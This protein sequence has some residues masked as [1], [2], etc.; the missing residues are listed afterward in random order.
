MTPCCSRRSQNSQFWFGV[1]ATRRELELLIGFLKSISTTSTVSLG[2]GSCPPHSDRIHGRIDQ[3]RAAPDDARIC[4]SCDTVPTVCW[5]VRVSSRDAQIHFAVVF[6]PRTRRGS[7][8][9]FEIRIWLLW[10]YPSISCLA[11]AR[12]FVHRS[13]DSRS[14]ARREMSSSISPVYQ[15]RGCGAIL[16]KFQPHGW[17]ARLPEATFLAALEL[18][19]ESVPLPG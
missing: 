14:G 5:R 17:G 3:Y 12:N 4:P 9:F 15:D 16:R 8:L 18:A 19:P 7:L 10:I 2:P 1:S 11:C 6:V 13:N